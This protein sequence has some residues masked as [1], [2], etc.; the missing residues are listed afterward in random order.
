MLS[1]KVHLISRINPLKY[2]FEKP[3]LVGRSSKWLLLLS[4][5]EIIHV[6]QKCIKAQAIANHLVDATVP[7]LEPIREEF[8]DE[9]I[10]LI[11]SNF[12][13]STNLNQVWKVYFDGAVNK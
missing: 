1:H 9:K 12:S 4:E 13:G 10:L 7:D 6:T 3:T 2:L 11:T 5:F 8:P